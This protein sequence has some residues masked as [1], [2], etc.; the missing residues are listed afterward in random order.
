MNSSIKEKADE[1]EKIVKIYLASN[2]IFRKD[3]KSNELE[4]RF[5]TNPKVARPVS[6][7]DYDNVVKQ[8]YQSG[9][10]TDNQSGLSILR[11]YSEELD[12]KTGTT[13][14]FQN[15]RAEISGL[16][17]IQHYCKTNSIQNILDLPSTS[18]AIADKIKFTKKTSAMD[19]AGKYINPVDF[20]DFNFRVSY[21]YE[22]DFNVRSNLGR[23]VIQNWNDKK[24]TFRYINRVQFSHPELPIFVDVSIVKTSKKTNGVVL[25]QYTIQDAG[26]LTNIEHY[27]IEL[28]VDNSR[29]GVG[30]PYNNEKMLLVAL[31]KCIRIVLGGIQGTHYPISYKERDDVLSAYMDILY[32]PD[33]SIKKNT[34]VLPKHFIGPASFTLQLENIQD[35]PQSSVPNIREKYT[36]TDKADGDRKLLFISSTGK[37]YMIDTNMNVVYTG[38][39]TKNKDVFNTIIDGE[40]IKYDKHGKYYNVFAAFDVYYI[41]EK[42]VRSHPF[43]RYED[44]ETDDP[45]KQEEKKKIPRLNLLRKAIDVI[46]PVS[47]AHINDAED[48]KKKACDF[49][50]LCKSFYASSENLTIFQGCSDILSKTKE[51][52]FEYNTDGLIFTPS[53]L[54]VGSE[55]AGVAGPLYKTTWASSFKW[56]PPEFNTID[57]LVTVKKDKSGRDEIHTVFQ[58]G[59]NLSGAQE[60]LQYKTLVLRCGFDEKKHG[61]INPSQDVIDGKTPSPEDVDNEDG[62][63]PVPFVPTDPYDRNASYCNVMLNDTG[64]GEL[65]LLTEE[66]EF[67]EENTIVEFKYD[68][69]KQGAWKWVPLRVRYDKTTEFKAGL[70]NYGNAYHVANNNWHSIHNPITEE[71]IST[72]TNIPEVRV[73]EDVYYNRSSKETNTRSLRDFHNLYVKN[74]LIV[75]VSQRNDILIDYAVGKGGDFSKWIQSNLAFVF[76]IDVSKDNI[77]NRLDGAYAR[78]LNFRKKT[79]DMPSALFVNG[80]SGLNIRSGEAFPSVK[81]KEIC[82]AVFGQGPKDAAVLGN[83]VYKQYGVAQSGFQVSSCQFA[84]HYFFE[85]KTVFHRF[86]QNVSECTKVGGYFIGTCYDGKTVFNLLRNKNKG[87]G[88]TFIRNDVKIYELLKMYDETGFP[89]DEQS[90]GYAID[91]YQETINQIFREYLVNFEFVTRIAE[92]YGF[93]LATPEDTKRMGLPSGT[94]LF[95]ELYH[96][97]NSEVKQFPKR[98]ADY[99]TA[100]EMNSDERQ[101]SFMN[102]Y[103]VFKKVRS[104]NAGKISTVFED[105]IEK[106]EEKTE[107]EIVEK[108][109]VKVVKKL[110][111]PKIT[112]TKFVVE[113]GKQVKIRVAKV[114][115]T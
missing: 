62:Y 85:N 63:Q 105:V 45:K 71:M 8:L 75:G 74:K 73:N 14:V 19:D 95:S 25:P 65:V 2:P 31:R 36:V 70:K 98:R 101:I 30:T 40:H 15:L 108:D 86:M 64:N 91:V 67:F 13:R 102:R 112:L 6:K 43:I 96:Q 82:R 94:G 76:G 11:I 72:G 92:D 26:V 59:R 106:E 4:I 3:R 68:I 52:L 48:D 42:D 33:K 10:T 1:F 66:R 53:E 80:N 114:K 39:M 83:G 34:R 60:V 61:Y 88:I 103:F 32:P 22:Q 97:M 38:S 20:T 24:K 49:R 46:K 104:V 17:L 84:F 81:D 23:D 51:G 90:L 54:G 99:G 18:S 93:V 37:L 50:V 107:E 12:K 41:N 7:I 115:E 100:L 29:V 109:M 47:S 35:V 56:K 110:D 87:E 89:D 79:K 44:A 28:E 27:E 16:D 9:F 78:Y 5:G 57:F 69:E 58:E 111:V 77:D 21:Q 113:T 55:R